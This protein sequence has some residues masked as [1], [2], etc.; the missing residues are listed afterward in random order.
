MTRVYNDHDAMY[1]VKKD[2]EWCE[3]IR[4]HIKGKDFEITMNDWQHPKELICPVCDKV[5]RKAIRA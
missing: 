1:P 2:G 3:A 4:C 5:F